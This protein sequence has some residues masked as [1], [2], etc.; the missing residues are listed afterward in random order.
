MSRSIH[1]AALRHAATTALVALTW[2]ASAS[3]LID[4]T[5]PTLTSFNAPSSVD[6]SDNST[7]ISVAFIAK[8]DLSGVAFV[9]GYATGPSGQHVYFYDNIHFPGKTISSIIMSA[10][11]TSFLQPGSYTFVEADVTDVAGNETVYDQSELSALGNITFTVRNT[12]NVDAHPPALASGK[13]VT[14]SASLS[15]SAPGTDQPPFVGVTIDAADT[16]DTAL[17]GIR[18]ADVEFCL[19]ARAHCF[20]VDQSE[21]ASHGQGNI[22]NLRLGHQLNR[23]SD[24]PGT[25]QIATFYM[26]DY[27]GNL[28]FLNSVHFGGATDFSTYFP[29]TTIQIK[30]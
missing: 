15:A 5:P 14:S 16:G 29:T 12:G 6:L 22:K 18:Y 13:I 19:P 8:D 28:Q 4:S 21:D 26:D 25:Y 20:R 10:D 30:P 7:P 24:V 23:S 9:S 1:Q 11:Q 2:P 3:G 27:A 17:A